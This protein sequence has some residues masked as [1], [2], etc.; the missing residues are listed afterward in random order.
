MLDELRVE[1]L[2]LIE[3]AELRLGPGLNVLTGETG[4]G[5]TVLAHALDLLLGG[6]P[7]PGIVRPGAAE[8]YVEGVFALPDGLPEPLRE[9]LADRLAPD[10]DEV[11]LARR[12]SAEGRTRAY[13]GGRSATA[14]DL[15]DVGGALLSFY[16]QHE[17]RKLTLASA[18]LD[19]LDGFCGPE[20][21][22]AAHR[23]RRRLR[24]RAGARSAELEELRARAGARDRE[25]DLLEW[26]LEEIERADPERG[27]GGRAARR[28]RAAAPPRGPARRRGGRGR[29]A[30]RAES[31]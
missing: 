21:A 22:G 19:I 16:G 8:A 9:A 27:G 17:H 29:G 31:G 2:L 28:A 24:P 14:G 12:V 15:R 30:A 5:K 7:R 26:E 11:V 20:Q 1:N 13:L 3:R 4:A 6:K 18:Q 25:L 23:V 10:A